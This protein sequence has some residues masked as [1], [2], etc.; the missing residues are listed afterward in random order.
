MEAIPLSQIVSALFVS[1]I[2]L[3]C[4]YTF[5]SSIMFYFNL[6][7]LKQSDV[8]NFIFLLFLAVFIGFLYS[9]WNF[10][11]LV[12]IVSTTEFN[13]NIMNNLFVTNI[14][15]LVIYMSFSARKFNQGKPSK[16]KM[17]SRLICRAAEKGSKIRL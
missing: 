7:G 13:K 10:L 4:L 2:G 9:S 15:A 5:I 8:K 1:T 12:G 11:N 3:T 6:H 17:L 16:K 14:L